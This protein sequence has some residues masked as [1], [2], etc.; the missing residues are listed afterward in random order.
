MPAH[1]LDPEEEPDIETGDF[2]QTPG[3]GGTALHPIS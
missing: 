2:S 1:L 3:A